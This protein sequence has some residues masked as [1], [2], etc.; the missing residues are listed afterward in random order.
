MKQIITV[1]GEMI[2]ILAFGFMVL[3]LFVWLGTMVLF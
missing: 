3:R 2:I 1:M